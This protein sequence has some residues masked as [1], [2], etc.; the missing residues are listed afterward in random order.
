MRVRIALKPPLP[1]MEA[2]SAENI[3]AGD[4]WQYE[5]KWDGFRCIAF[6][7]GEKIYLQSKAG[8]PLA[9]Y[10]PDIVGASPNCP[11]N[12][13]FWMANLL[14][15]SAA[16]FHSM[17]CNCVCIRPRVASRN[18]PRPIQ[19]CTSSSISLL[20][21]DKCMC[22]ESYENA[23]D[24]SRNLHAAISDRPKICVFLRRRL[25]TELPPTGLRKSEAI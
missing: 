4:G 19:P 14:S 3:P 9:R 2:R 23:D 7:N 6:R 18:W 24:S 22:S 20:R 5:P 17:H 12:N 16:L 15:P 1:P 8:Q 25:T 11:S 21:M 10:F 13:L